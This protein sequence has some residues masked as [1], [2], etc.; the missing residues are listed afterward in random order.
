VLSSAK[1]GPAT[2]Y[3]LSAPAGQTAVTQSTIMLSFNTNDLKHWVDPGTD[4][5]SGPQGV[6]PSIFATVTGNTFYLTGTGHVVH[7]PGTFV[8]SWMATK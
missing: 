1:A 6:I 3:I 2:C 4:G 8:P 7:S 5:M